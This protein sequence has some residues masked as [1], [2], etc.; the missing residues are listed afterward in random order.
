[1]PLPGL[2][3]RCGAVFE[4]LAT[5]SIDLDDTRRSASSQPQ[6]QQSTTT[7]AAAAAAA[8]AA[9][10]KKTSSASSSVITS[11]L[12]GGRSKTARLHAAHA[13]SMDVL[14]SMA[15]EMGTHTHT[16][17]KHI[18]RCFSSMCAVH[19]FAFSAS[20][21]LVGRQEGHPACKK[22]SVGVLAWLS[23][24]SEVHCRL[25]RCH[26]HLP[27]LAA[28]KSRLVLPFWY[29]LICGLAGKV[30]SYRLEYIFVYSS[31]ML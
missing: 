6:S 15:L 19:Q 30:H 24:W 29:R 11:V 18:F 26:S 25:P 22:L 16:A 17:W 23:V 28:V 7:T 9:A 12:S 31:F 10:D 1:M 4:H 8:A 21:L 13:L 27:S 14:L 5:A 2:Y 3:D 20:T